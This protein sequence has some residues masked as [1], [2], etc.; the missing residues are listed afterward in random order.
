MNRVCDI[1]RRGNLVEYASLEYSNIS[2]SLDI[3]TECLAGEKMLSIFKQKL[4]IAPSRPLT[5]DACNYFM[6]NCCLVVNASLFLCSNCID[7]EIGIEEANREINKI[8]RRIVK[9]HKEKVLS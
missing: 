6:A 5:C 9:L 3:C 1:C 2:N 7:V 8:V 4:F